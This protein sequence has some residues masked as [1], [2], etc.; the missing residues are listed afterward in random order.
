MA[1]ASPVISMSGSTTAQSRRAVL[2]VVIVVCV[3]FRIIVP[4]GLVCRTR[5]LAVGKDAAD[6]LAG[7]VAIAAVLEILVGL[8]VLR[9]IGAVSRNADVRTAGVQDFL[10]HLQIGQGRLALVL[11]VAFDVRVHILLLGLAIGRDVGVDGVIGVPC[12]MGEALNLI[13]RRRVLYVDDDLLLGLVS[14][15]AASVLGF[16]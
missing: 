11:Q 6:V 4:I 10:P 5:L 8:F 16:D 12:F 7:L 9:M 1:T 14:V 2:R 15:G 13:L 3:G